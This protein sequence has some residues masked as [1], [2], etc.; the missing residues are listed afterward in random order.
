MI[1]NY[2]LAGLFSASPAGMRETLSF[3]KPD[4]RIGAAR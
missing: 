1:R 2:L 3:S 4:C